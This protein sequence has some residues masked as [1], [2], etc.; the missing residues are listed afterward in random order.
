MGGVHR[1]HLEVSEQPQ[2][3]HRLEQLAHLAEEPDHRGLRLVEQQRQHQRLQRSVDVAVQTVELGEERRRGV[4][5]AVALPLL[6]PA[7]QTSFNKY[8]CTQLLKP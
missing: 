4:E 2:R 5:G 3:P 8:I 6:A 7:E 1:R